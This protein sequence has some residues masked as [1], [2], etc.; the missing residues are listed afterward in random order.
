MERIP[1]D[2]GV[3]SAAKRT[4]R[5]R[6]K[7]G[8]IGEVSLHWAFFW[9]DLGR[10]GRLIFDLAILNAFDGTFRFRGVRFETYRTIK[11]HVRVSVRFGPRPKL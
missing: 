9:T 5:M 1:P 3:L 7:N 2:G 11:S 6:S 10:F 8:G 4:Q